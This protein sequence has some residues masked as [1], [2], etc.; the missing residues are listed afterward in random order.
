M[1]DNKKM[2]KRLYKYRD[3]SSRTIDLIV[4]DKLF[5]ADPFTFNDPLDSRPSLKIDV[6][7]ASLEAILRDLIERRVSAATKVVKSLGAKSLELAKQRG[8]REATRRLEEL[9]YLATDP[10]YE[11]TQKHHQSLLAQYIESELLAHDNKGVLSLAERATCPLMWS[12][13]GDQHK[14]V[15]IG[16]SIPESEADKLHQVKYGRSRLVSA[17]DVAS[18]IQNYES[19]GRRVDEAVFLRKAWDWNY[20]REWRLIGPRGASSSILEL[21]EIIFG[22]RCEPSVKFTIVKALAKRSHQIKF[23][24]LREAA[25]T[26]KLRKYP[27]RKDDEL[28]VHFP[29]RGRDIIDAFS[30]VK[31]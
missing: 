1:A 24:E 14:G 4:A 22:M 17:S 2:P 13:Y 12:H 20:E 3:L 7:T 31:D 5:F 16:Y 27:I 25:G 30:R 11:D 18:M 9:A 8:R 6:P 19:A 21:S 23:F 10:E 29:R 28:F 26:F 15:C